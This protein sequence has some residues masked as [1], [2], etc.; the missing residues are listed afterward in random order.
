MAVNVLKDM[1]ILR[2]VIFTVQFYGG[3][4][5]IVGRSVI[6]IIYVYIINLNAFQIKSSLK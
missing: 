4:L 2:D 3:Y 1:A 5:R 6:A